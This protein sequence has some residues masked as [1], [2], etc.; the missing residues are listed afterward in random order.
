VRY[1]VLTFSVAVYSLNSYL[2]FLLKYVDIAKDP[3]DIG[4]Y[5]GLLLAAF[6]AAQ[7]IMGPFWGWLSDH[8]GRRK[9]FAL[10]GAFGT[11]AGFLVF[12]FSR[13]YATVVD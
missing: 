12:G 2:Y 7:S 1:K 9:P 13:N 3:D 8:V 6:L 5:L 4:F 10:S 11:M